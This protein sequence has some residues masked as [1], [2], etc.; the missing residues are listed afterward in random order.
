MTTGEGAGALEDRAY[1]GSKGFIAN[2][3]AIY[4]GCAATTA[5]AAGNADADK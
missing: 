2:R 1:I 3:I 5:L 4:R